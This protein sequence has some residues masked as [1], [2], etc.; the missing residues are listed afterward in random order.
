MTVVDIS[1]GSLSLRV[2]TRGGSI[3]GFWKDGDGRRVPLLR[4]ARTVDADAPDASC[5]PL[6]PFGNRITGNRFVFEEVEYTLRPNTE[7]DAHYLHGDGWQASWH[8][9]RQTET[10]I[11]MSFEQSGGTTPYEYL[12]SQSF[13][14]DDDSLTVALQVEN[15]GRQTLPFGLGWHPYFPLTPQTKLEACAEAF[16]TEAEGWLPGEQTNIPTDLDFSAAAGLP[17]RWVNNGFENWNGRGRISWP[18][19]GVALSMEADQIF[20]HAF[21]FLSDTTFDPEFKR[22]YFCF[23]PM[24]HLADG[25]N[26]PGLG[27]LTA[28]ARGE[29]LSGS[30]RLWAETL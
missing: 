2:S 7:W 18:E 25:H 16:W 29:T 21:L 17:H 22:D 30:F 15:R 26:L 1:S 14:L 3:L 10:F 27:G 11:E 20:R 28:L 19:Y 5:F 4:P 13:T 6:V 8:I 23:E 24:T 12:A 9:G